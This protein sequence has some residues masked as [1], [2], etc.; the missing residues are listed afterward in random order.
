MRKMRNVSDGE[1][2][3]R[4]NNRWVFDCANRLIT[5]EGMERKRAFAQAA[6]AFHLLEQLG[7]GEVRFEYLKA[8][9]ELRK[10]RGTLCH[11]ISP[12]LDSYEFKDDKPDVGQ[13][14]FGIIVYFDLD[15]EEF[16]SFK[17]ERLIGWNE[18][19][20]KLENEDGERV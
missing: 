18:K 8:N 6:K 2:T 17:A 13:K 1:Q 14:D 15:K 7:K 9:G 11:G 20:R 12:E 5:D 19:M 10:A 3:R 4:L 16:R